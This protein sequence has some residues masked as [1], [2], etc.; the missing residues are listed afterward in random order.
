MLRPFRRCVLNRGHSGTRRDPLF[1]LCTWFRLEEVIR[2]ERR[3]VGQPAEQGTSNALLGTSIGMSRCATAAA[4]MSQPTSRPSDPAQ[5]E[6]GPLLHAPVASAPLYVRPSDH[7]GRGVFAGRRFAKG[8]LIE[9]APV[10]VVPAHQRPVLDRTALY[11]YY[12]GWGANLDEGAIALGFGSLYNHSYRPNATY[13][14][15]FQART[16]RFFALRDIEANEEITL[17]YNGDPDDQSPVWFEVA[18]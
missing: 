10:L 7:S 2:D 4:T 8:E 15:D 16:V 1:A 13:V 17:N 11:D 9:E 5:G 6:A 14:K 18:P 12:Y 3:R